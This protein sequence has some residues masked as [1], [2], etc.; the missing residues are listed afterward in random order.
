M[1]MEAVMKNKM[2]KQI[3]MEEKMIIAMQ[4]VIIKEEVMMIPIEI[5][6]KEM[7]INQLETVIKEEMIKVIMKIER[8]QI[9]MEIETITEKILIAKQIKTHLSV[10][11]IFIRINSILLSKVME[12][13]MKKV[14]EEIMEKLIAK[15]KKQINTL[16][17]IEEILIIMKGHKKVKVKLLV[18][19]IKRL[20]KKKNP[21]FVLMDL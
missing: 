21:V 16:K 11:K 9:L 17:T 12:E 10:L 15:A 18:K 7:I 4:I 13:V 5:I 8:I 2:I 1:D 6:T 14:M 20:I 19:A 3:E